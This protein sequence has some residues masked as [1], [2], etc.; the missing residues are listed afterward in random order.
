MGT[1]NEEIWPGCSNL[2]VM[3][4]FT[5]SRKPNRLHELIPPASVTSN[6]FDLL[7]RFV[8]LC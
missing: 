7:S 1:P 8:A 6:T 2:P 3:Q 4:K 5:F